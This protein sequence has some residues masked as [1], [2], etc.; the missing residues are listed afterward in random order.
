MP[1]G[2]NLRRD[3]TSLRKSEEREHLAN[4][5]NWTCTTCG[6]EILDGKNVHA[7]ED[8]PGRRLKRDRSKR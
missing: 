7:S 4:G 6:Q 5:S 8:C 2:L 1:R 3:R